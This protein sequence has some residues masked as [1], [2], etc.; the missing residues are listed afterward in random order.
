MAVETA[1]TAKPIDIYARVS[2]RVRN[3]KREPSTEG[4]VAVCRVR[5]AEL[6]LGEGKVLIDPGRSA[7]NPAV[8]RET[9][10]ELMGRLEREGAGGVIGFDL[11]RFRRRPQDGERRSI[12]APDGVG[13]C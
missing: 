2:Y 11:E 1:C 4:Q 12:L 6:G 10:D 8:K 9:W 13:E 7:W 3:E 5:L